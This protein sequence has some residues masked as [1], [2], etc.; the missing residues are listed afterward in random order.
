[1]TQPTKATKATKAKKIRYTDPRARRL[2]VHA[3][4]ALIVVTVP[5]CGLTTNMIAAGGLFGSLAMSLTGIVVA[6]TVTAAACLWLAPR[7]E[8]AY[9]RAVTAEVLAAVVAAANL[10]PPSGPAT[11]ATVTPE[12]VTPAPAGAVRPPVLLPASLTRATTATSQP[13][14]DAEIVEGTTPVSAMTTPA[15]D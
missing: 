14:E 11:P 9:H 4:V 13:V 7:V 1:M 10:L 8:A 2:A 6:L 3:N 5:A 15:V 12:P